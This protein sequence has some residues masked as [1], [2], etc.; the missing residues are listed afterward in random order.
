MGYPDEQMEWMAHPSQGAGPGDRNGHFNPRLGSIL[1]EHKYGWPMVCAGKDQPHPLP[2][3]ASS[4]AGT[5]KICEE[6]NGSVSLA[7]DRQY[8]R[9]GLHQQSRV[10]SLQDTGD[11]NKGLLDVVSGK[12]HSHPSTTHTRCPELQAGH[13]VQNPQGSVRLEPGQGHFLKI[14][15]AI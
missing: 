8:H 5:D 9:S 14:K 3:T 2:R 6:P 7:Q 11:P 12:E 10:H 4:Y 13:R 15:R 1:P